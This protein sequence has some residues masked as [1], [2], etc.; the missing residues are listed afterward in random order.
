MSILLYAIVHDWP[1]LLPIVFCSVLCL[2]VMIE[3]YW[4]FRKNRVN[5]ADFIHTL[6]RELDNGLDHAKVAAERQKGILGELAAEG[7]VIV[8]KHGSGSG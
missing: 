7:I 5:T 3:R 6:Q 1:V 4:F 8:G 2:A